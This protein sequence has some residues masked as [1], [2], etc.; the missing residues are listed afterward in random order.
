MSY[1]GLIA[2]LVWDGTD[3]VR[4]PPE[5]G[6]PREDQM[7]GT[8]RERLVELA[9]RVC[10]D[11]LGTG[12]ASGS[13]HENIKT[14]NHGALWEHAAFTA[15][16]RVTDGVADRCF[17][18]HLPGQS[19]NIPYAFM[20]RPG[21]FAGWNGNRTA[22]HVTLNL[23]TVVEWDA[24]SE[25]ILARENEFWRREGRKSFD[26]FGRELRKV[27]HFLA[28]M[29][30]PREEGEIP[31][32]R[33]KGAEGGNEPWRSD[34]E[35]WITLFLSGSRG[36][37]HEL[38]R[39]GDWT[40][41]SQR[42]TRYVD[43]SESP[44]VIHP[45][46]QDYLKEHPGDQDMAEGLQDIEDDAGAAYDQLVKDL[47]P[48]LVS[49]GIDKFSARKQARGAARGFL[50]NAL[51]TEVIFSA[52]VTQWRHMLR[53]RLADAADAEIRAVFALA[54]EELKRSRYGDRFAE[55]ST[56]PAKDGIGVSLI[57][58]GAK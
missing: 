51:S 52:S 42:S 20:N 1:E 7:Q 19:D 36:F 56:G 25:R 43:E 2:R 54:L 58:G 26:A 18:L 49:R 30:V 34:E 39:H 55:F 10:Y 47:E 8:A 13:Y 50:G 57:G 35:K 27:A 48:W 24:M 46:I 5:M 32:Y 41:I 4:I 53:M 21:V 31:D 3:E 15:D 28:P 22:L 29:I 23:R 38:V 40:A 9:G 11:S 12:R 45:L 16:F 17:P 14:I 44:W 33:L 6:T 37:S